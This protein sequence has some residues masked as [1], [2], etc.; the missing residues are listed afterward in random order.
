MSSHDIAMNDFAQVVSGI[1]ART[2]FAAPGIGEACVLVVDTSALATYAAVA[3]RMLDADERHRAA[4]FHFERDRSVYLLAHALWRMVL[5]VCL[6]MEASAVPLVRAPWGQPQLPD[7]PL[8]TSLSHSGNWVAIAVGHAVTVGV[9]IECSPA[10]IALSDLSTTICTPA[11]AADMQDL[12]VTVREAAL[13]ALWTRKE[14]LLKA[15]G[16]GLLES[17]S[18]LPAAT[19]APVAPPSNSAHP[20]CRVCELD[21]PAG[22]AGAFAAPVTVGLCRLYVPAGIDGTNHAC[23]A[24][25]MDEPPSNP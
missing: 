5:G 9:D 18:T 24:I 1:L 20:P 8:A 11:E 23:H 17:P 22:V 25:S 12:P 19:S 13:L 7:T 3:E 16:T 6:G 10:R 21:L 2:G 15:F 14:A 4:R